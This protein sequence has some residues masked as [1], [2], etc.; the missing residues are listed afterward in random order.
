MAIEFRER[1]VS[2]ILYSVNAFWS[3]S[4]MQDRHIVD[5]TWRG[6]L[7]TLD[8][9]YTQLY[10]LNYAKCISTITHN[11]IS[12]WERFEFNTANKT[13][14][15]NPLYPHAYTLPANIKSVHLLRESPR[16]ISVLPA[17]S[18]ILNSGA[19]LLP[20]GSVRFPGDVIYS[21]DDWFKFKLKCTVCDGTGIYD[22][23]PCEICS[24]TGIVEGVSSQ[25]GFGV[26]TVKYYK[27][28]DDIADYEE[29]I[30][31]LGDFVIDETNKVIAFKTQ[32]YEILWSE[33]AIR[34][35]EIIYDN[36]GSLLQFYK[37]DSYR[38]LRQLQGLWY[39][40]WHGSTIQNLEIGLN[41]VT[42]LPFITDPGYVESISYLKNSFLTSREMTGIDFESRIA[43]PVYPSAVADSSLRDLL[44]V[45]RMQPSYAFIENTDYII[46]HEF[47]DAHDYENLLS[48]T[49]FNNI[50]SIPSQT[51]I[52]Y[53]KLLDTPT[54][55]AIMPGDVLDIYFRD[56]SGNYIIT[57]AGRDYTIPDEYTPEVVVNQYLNQ[58]EP[59]TEAINVYDYKN[60]PNWWE[61]LL[62]YSHDSTYYIKNGRVRFD[63]GIVWDSHVNLDSYRKNLAKTELLY[64]HTFLVSLEKA[65]IPTTI[66]GVKII[67]SFLDTIK[68]SYSHY[69]I[70][71]TLD[72]YEDITAREAHFCVTGVLNAIDN[73]G[74]MQRLDDPWVRKNYDRGINFDRRR[75]HENLLVAKLPLDG[76]RFIS[77]T[78]IHSCT[79][80]SLEG[81]KLDSGKR[82]DSYLKASQL[83]ITKELP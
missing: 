21:N 62:G 50:S 79:F 14:T 67:K 53:F 40:Y 81:R 60:Y 69:I 80:D 25:A 56:G 44:I 28:A 26:E 45:N 78:R 23:L 1:S 51:Q 58:F 52:A 71:C 35:T 24:A 4:L 64:H 22:S 57:V 70:R 48:F 49:D 65:A 41:V 37:K 77:D 38:Y 13:E 39:T 3:A 76:V 30:T 8:N 82:A 7:N 75:Y 11:W 16:E 36:F 83:T 72:Y 5:Q 18:V 29:G 74:P 68:P 47:E 31:P 42:D 55:R 10:Q 43:L 15:F 2:S 9:L 34:D 54:T 66:S 32:P 20:D 17:L 46:F 61:N 59:L 12:H 6:Y 73:Q 19:I 63:S 33:Y 27:R